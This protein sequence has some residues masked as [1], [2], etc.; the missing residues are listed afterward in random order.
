M[1]SGLSAEIQ[2]SVAKSMAH[3]ARE[4]ALVARALHSPSGR[5]LLDRIPGR[6][7]ALRTAA[8]DFVA[9]G[10]AVE[11]QPGVLLASP[12][13][14]EHIEPFVQGIAAMAEVRP[15][16]GTF[17]SV[18]TPPGGRSQYPAALQKL[19]VAASEILDTSRAMRDVAQSAEHS[20]WIFTP[21]V[22]DPG[23]AFVLDLFGQT[24][25]T[26]RVLVLRVRGHLTKQTL[27]NSVGALSAMGVTVM[28]YAVVHDDGFE[29]FHAKAIVADG[30][31]A[32]VGSANMLLYEKQS[33]ELGVLIEGIGVDVVTT[34][35]R[36]VI[37]CSS[38]IS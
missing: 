35:L 23:M 3:V 26:E 13:L 11:I 25:A 14:P 30:S 21:F 6:G 10:W 37:C 22:N 9:R 31:R 17:R 38:Q 16:Q 20:L 15:E 8:A 5:A 7:Q 33:L 27:A 19:G 1:R 36:A 24:K 32:Y 2:L 4:A 18:V 28:D 34:A 12:A 29:T